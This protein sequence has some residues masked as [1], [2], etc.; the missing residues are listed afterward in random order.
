MSVTD[1]K[2]DV[3]INRMHE[4]MPVTRQS[5]NSTSGRKLRGEVEHRGG[6]KATSRDR[7]KPVIGDLDAPRSGQRYRIDSRYTTPAGV[8]ELALA[9]AAA[10][11][12]KTRRHRGRRSSPAPSVVAV[13]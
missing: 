5:H 7:Y 6:C 4:L 1:L 13:P 8:D 2:A 12:P 9:T 3:V 11:R 10:L